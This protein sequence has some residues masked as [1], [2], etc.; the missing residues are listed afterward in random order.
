MLKKRNRLTVKEFSEVFKNGNKKFSKN[1]LFIY[2]FKIEK[3]K[4]TKFFISKNLETSF[5][6]KTY[7]LNKEKKISVAISKK[8]EK[9][10]VQRIQSRRIIY[11]ILK[12]NFEKIPDNFQGIFLITKPILNLDKKSL[13][14]EILKELKSFKKLIQ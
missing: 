11:R 13:S 8:V 5:L 10:A 12:E 2:L 7:F 6:K 3:K 14:E 9:K 4:N 1:F